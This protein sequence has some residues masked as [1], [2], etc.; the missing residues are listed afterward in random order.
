M[1][2]AGVPAP[3]WAIDEFGRDPVLRTPVSQRGV[4]QLLFPNREFANAF[5]GGGEER[6]M[7]N[8]VSFVVVAILIW[9]DDASAPVPNLFI[10]RRAGSRAI[11]TL[12]HS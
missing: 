11:P 3:R 4:D 9:G 2:Q 6:R 10:A 5:A 7:T 8:F 12:P 1:P